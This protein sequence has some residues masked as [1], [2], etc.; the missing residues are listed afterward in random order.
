MSE[1]KILIAF[2]TRYG[3]TRVTANQIRDILQE[4]GLS[5][6]IV[7]LKETKKKKW[8][9][10]DGYEIIV[11]GSSIAMGNWMGEPRKF[12]RKNKKALSNKK[13]VLFVSCSLC[14]EDMPKAQS[15][16][17]DEFIKEHELNPVLTEIFGPCIDLTEN[18][19]LGK[20]KKGILKAAIED[21]IKSRDDIS[22][23]ET[24]AT[25]LREVEKIE[26]FAEQIAA[27]IS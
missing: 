21:M 3:S 18:S 25:D 1:N 19:D 20:M 23:S 26:S 10:A 11:V 22:V 16:Y 13:L 9:K 17:I 15:D 6:D 27:K 24:E 7:D 5:V 4:K 14:L 8:P 12:L 2:G